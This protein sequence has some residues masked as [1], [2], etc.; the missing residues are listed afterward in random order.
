MAGGFQ[1]RDPPQLQPV[2]KGCLA[3]YILFPHTIR[4][5]GGRYRV[6]QVPHAIYVRSGA[7]ETSRV[8]VP[9]QQRR[10]RRRQQ[11]RR[12]GDNEDDDVGDGVDEEGVL[13]EGSD[14][15]E[16]SDSSKVRR[17]CPV[18]PD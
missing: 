4:H 17:T 1:A 8:D 11:Q 5:G 2:A 9:Q 15:A 10:R 12:G 16:A 18:D 14:E 13:E 6:R 7:R 3:W